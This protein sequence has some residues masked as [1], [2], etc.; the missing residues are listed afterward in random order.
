[1]LFAPFTCG[2]Q[3]FCLFMVPQ[4]SDEGVE[5]SLH[6]LRQSVNSQADA[7]IGHAALGEVV[8]ANLL[9]A[10]AAA[11]LGS[12]CLGQFGGLFLLFLLVEP[13][14]QDRHRPQFVLRL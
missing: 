12:P 3:S 7:V 10:V 14:P 1:M 9:A 6:Y 11:Y 2:L 8:G 13:G 5:V 4:C